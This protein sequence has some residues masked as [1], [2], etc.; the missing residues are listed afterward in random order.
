MFTVPDSFIQAFLLN[1]LV[2]ILAI[3]VAVFAP[4]IVK[5][6]VPMPG[7]GCPF[8]EYEALP[9]TGPNC[10]ECGR[11]LPAQLLRRLEPTKLP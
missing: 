8:C 10:P 4:R 1:L 7:P 11:E 5:W 3:P 9:E 2:P 6:L